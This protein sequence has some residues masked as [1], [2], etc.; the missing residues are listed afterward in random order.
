M[1]ALAWP[2]LSVQPNSVQWGLSAITQVHVSPLSGAV[3]TQELPGAYWVTRI[4][5]R[6][7]ADD[8]RLMQAWLARLRGR[9]GRA[10]LWNMAA[11]YPVGIGGGSPVVNGAGQTGTTLAVAGAPVS[12]SGWLKAGDFIGVNGC[13]HMITADATTDAGGAASL[14]I[15]P[16]LRSSPASGAAI[17]LAKP[18]ASFMLLDDK[19]GWTRGLGVPLYEFTLDFR[20]VW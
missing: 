6:L 17:T 19:Q 3:Q 7:Q 15:E 1:S 14:T 16:P 12:L 10:A 2:A 20:E 18:T 4:A 13:V 11:P 8:A 5:L 9:A